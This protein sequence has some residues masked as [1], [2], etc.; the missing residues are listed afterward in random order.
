MNSLEKFASDMFLFVGLAQSAAD[1]IIEVIQDGCKIEAAK[2]LSRRLRDYK[3]TSENMAFSFERI[4]TELD[5]EV[6]KIEN[7]RRTY[8][9]FQSS[10]CENVCL[11]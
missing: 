6:E 8:K 11:D 3:R 9:K 5:L 2:L 7:G 10:I 4:A 1:A